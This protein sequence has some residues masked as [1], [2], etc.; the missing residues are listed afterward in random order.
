MWWKI[1]FWILAI[2]AA[3]NVIALVLQILDWQVSGVFPIL[4]SVLYALA[5]YAYIYKKHIFSQQ[6]WKIWLVIVL[7]GYILRWSAFWQVDLL[8]SILLIF[9]MIVF[10]L[11][12]WY[13]M[14]RLGFGMKERVNVATDKTSKK[15]VG[16]K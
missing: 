7:L 9:S 8:T 10:A 3:W 1:Y 16:T 11:P 2:L 12:A 4:A 5:V 14:Y 6:K 15:K 13:C